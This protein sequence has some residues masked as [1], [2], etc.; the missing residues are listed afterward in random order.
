MDQDQLKEFK[1][2]L[3]KTKQVNSLTQYRYGNWIKDLDLQRLVSEGQTYLNQYV[4]SKGNH[5]QVR[6]AVLN[7]LEYT[8]LNKELD[9]PPKA[10][11]RENKRIIRSIAEVEIQSV[12]DYLYAKSFK[13]GLIFDLIY[14]GALR[15]FEIPT[16]RINS[17]KWLEWIEDPTTPCHL[18]IKGKGDK[19]RTVL[20]NSETMLKLYG[21][22]YEKYG[23]GN[24]KRMELFANSPHLIFTK[25]SGKPINEWDVWHVV[26]R[27]SL[28]AIGRNIRTHELRHARATELEKKGVQIRDIKSYLGHSSLATTEIY[29][30]RA[31]SESLEAIKKKLSSNNKNL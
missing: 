9:M 19:D 4:Q 22:Y 3:E 2:F 7:L 12:R 15:R 1:E 27:G 16:I 18:V 31:E 30:H 5:S 14:Q 13:K 17:F 24:M 10:S 23:L 25:S 20:I 28:E 29:L 21:R 11:G 26:N 8:R 6:G